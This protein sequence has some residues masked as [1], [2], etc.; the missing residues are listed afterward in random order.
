[1][2]DE[3]TDD[4]EETIMQ[5]EIDDESEE[6]LNDLQRMYPGL[7]REEIVIAALEYLM[8]QDND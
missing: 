8:E 5:F 6:I 2:T 1:M 7:S 3:K 4:S